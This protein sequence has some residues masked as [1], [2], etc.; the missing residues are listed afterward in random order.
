MNLLTVYFSFILLLYLSD[1]GLIK[2][3]E[4]LIDIGISVDTSMERCPSM[5]LYVTGRHRYISMS[6]YLRLYKVRYL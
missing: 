2:S 4:S 5:E 1:N 6:I 3:G